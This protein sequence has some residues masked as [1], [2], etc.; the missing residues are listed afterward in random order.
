[1]NIED[2]KKYWDNF[3]VELYALLKQIKKNERKI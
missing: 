2:Y 1:M 3:N